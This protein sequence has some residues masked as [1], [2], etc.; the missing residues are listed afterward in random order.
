[1]LQRLFAASDGQRW[2]E[3]YSSDL[4]GDYVIRPGQHWYVD[5]SDRETNN[6]LYDVKVIMRNGQIFEDRIDVCGQTL[7]IYGK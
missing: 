2:A 1:M 4:L 5:L 3:I 6:C 7:T